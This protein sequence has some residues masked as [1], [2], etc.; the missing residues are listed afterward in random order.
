MD[1][2]AGLAPGLTPVVGGEWDGWSKW[3]SDEPFEDH[4][5]PFYARR[6]ADGRMESGF[7]IQHKNMN[8]GGA[9]HGGALMAFADY[10][11]FTI[12]YDDLRGINSVTVTLNGEFAAA[13]P[14]G[15]LL[16]AR[17]EVVKAGRSLLFV[18]GLIDLDGASVLNFSGVLKLLRP[19]A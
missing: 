1:N 18:R 12:A 14:L 13:A 6:L 19:R 4:V 17:G 16:T 10:S 8:G 15:A 7:R 11:L 2:D 9:V 3:S 5:G